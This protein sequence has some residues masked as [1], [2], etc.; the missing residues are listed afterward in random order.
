MDQPPGLTR[1]SNN[2]R[3]KSIAL[4]VE[5]G[6]WGLTIEPIVLGM[7]VAPSISGLFLSIATMGAFLARQPFKIYVADTR[8]KRIT[9]RK[10]IA[11]NFFLL[12]ISISIIGL[13]AAIGFSTGYS[14]LYPILL[15]IP[16]GVIQLVYDGRGSSRSLL[17]E[18]SG[19]TALASVAASIAI[20][21]NWSIPLALGLWIILVARIIPTIFYVRAKIRLL[22]RKPTSTITV[23]TLHTVALLIMMSLASI[24]LIPMLAAFSML[25]LLIRALYALSSDRWFSSAKRI[26]ITELVFGAIT[27]LAAAIGYQLP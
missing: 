9:A 8:H 19:A 25:I 7:L 1:A 15:A 11:K 21:G 17:P 22:H 27:V 26:G 4:P 20:A 13:V 5:H 6:G 24:E 3:I 12:Y 2:V 14:F 23:I 10:V 18:L 16:F